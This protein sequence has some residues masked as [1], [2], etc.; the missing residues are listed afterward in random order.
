M[1]EAA[2]V[3]FIKNFNIEMTEEHIKALNDMAP[4]LI[5]YLLKEPKFYTQYD[6]HFK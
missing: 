6:K 2:A 5:E 1:Q 3:I 4:E